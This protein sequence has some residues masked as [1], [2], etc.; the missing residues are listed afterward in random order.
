MKENIQLGSSTTFLLPDDVKTGGDVA[1]VAIQLVQSLDLE[2]AHQKV[3]EW[4]N[5]ADKMVR[6]FKYGLAKEL[7]ASRKN[8]FAVTDFEELNINAKFKVWKPL[9]DEAYNMS[10]AQM[11]QM[12]INVL[13]AQGNLRDMGAVVEEIGDNWNNLSRNQQTA[14]AQT[15]AG[16]RQY[17]RM[18]A[19]FDNWD[20][21]QAAKSTSEGG[22]GELQK[23]QD[24]Y[25]ESMKAHL[26]ELTSEAEELY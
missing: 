5:V 17:S 19:L 16:T 9:N 25:M 26:N 13:D 24:I 3:I 2:L 18:M 15:I 20:M 6:L 10:V 8:E 7:V 22:A 1:G 23:Q 21:Y 11:K 4:Q 12:G 14:L